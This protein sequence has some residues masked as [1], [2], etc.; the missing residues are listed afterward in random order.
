MVQ[1]W[2]SSM[3]GVVLAN[4]SVVIMEYHNPEEVPE[5]MDILKHAGFKC[6]ILGEINT[7]YASKR[8]I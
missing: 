1:L 4:T 8:T 6:E 5:I 3:M 2:R 7:L